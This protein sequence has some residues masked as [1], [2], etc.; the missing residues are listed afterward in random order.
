MANDR[1]RERAFFTGEAHQTPVSHPRTHSAQRRCGLF[2]RC[3]KLGQQSLAYVRKFNDKD[4]IIQKH[5]QVLNSV[6]GNL[7]TE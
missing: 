7:E 6:L 3:A 2:G 5:E 1:G 4:I